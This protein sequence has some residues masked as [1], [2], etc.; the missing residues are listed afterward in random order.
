LSDKQ[1]NNEEFL[2]LFR[3]SLVSSD[4]DRLF[5]I[6]SELRRLNDD[7]FPDSKVVEVPVVA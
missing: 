3:E 4:P 6:R 5:K 2:R 7:Y 1:R